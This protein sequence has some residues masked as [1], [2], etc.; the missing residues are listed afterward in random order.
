M[1]HREA[2]STTV[3]SVDA[4]DLAFELV[5]LDPRGEAHLVLGAG[6]ATAVT[7]PPPAPVPVGEERT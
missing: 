1:T 7:P 3:A 2:G 6:Q 5:V 4:D